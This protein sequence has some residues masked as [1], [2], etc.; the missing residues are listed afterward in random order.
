M[1]HRVL[2]VALATLAIGCGQESS[3]ADPIHIGVLFPY[4]GDAAAVGSN[5]ERAVLMITQAINEDHEGIAGR[6]VEPLFR[7]TKSEPLHATRRAEEQVAAG[8]V[9]VIGPGGDEEAG[10]VFDVLA[11]AGVVLV[12]PLASNEIEGISSSE[13]PWFRLSP[14]TR[15]IGDAFAKELGNYAT[16]L[17][18]IYAADAYHREF[19]SALAARFASLDGP[20]PREIAFVIEIDEHNSSLG[21]LAHQVVAAWQSGIDGIVLAMNPVPAARLVSEV[22]ALAAGRPPRWFLSPRLKTDVFLYNVL[23]AMVE[24]ALGVSPEVFLQDRAP[25]V[26]LFQEV[27]EQALPVDSTY[28]VYDAV[29]LTLIAIDRVAQSGPVDAVSLAAA[30]FDV[31]RPGGIQVAWNE[32]GLALA[33]NRNEN[34][35]LQKIQYVGLTGPLRFSENGSRELARATVWSITGGKIIELNTIQ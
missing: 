3:P 28:F 15:L 11:D 35:S 30:L 4:T 25:F 26:T 31:A 23:P 16:S 29:A 20:S 14:T 19:A 13:H 1:R 17:A 22:A 27:W 12:S 2:A 21:A 32:I 33:Y 10:E 24:G 34:P 5:L 18:V 6:P 8:A 7:D 9:A